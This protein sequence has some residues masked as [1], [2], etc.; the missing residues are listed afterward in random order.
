MKQDICILVDE[1]DNIVGGSDKY[2]CHR[3][4]EGQ[5]QV[6]CC[7]LLHHAPYRQFSLAIRQRRFLCD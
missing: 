2:Q 6:N 3:F 1:A 7:R 5:P 4:V